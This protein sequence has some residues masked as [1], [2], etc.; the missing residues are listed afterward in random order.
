MKLYSVAAISC[1]DVFLLFKP[2][3]V[4]VASKKNIMEILIVYSFRKIALINCK[5]D[6]FHFVAKSATEFFN[7]PDRE[8]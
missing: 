4:S 7:T 6:L 8:C 3:A 5:E 2:M 1:S